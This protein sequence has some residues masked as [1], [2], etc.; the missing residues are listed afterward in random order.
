MVYLI[1]IRNATL[2]KVFT[3]VLDFVYAHVN[4]QSEL[5][6]RLGTMTKR[7]VRHCATFELCLFTCKI[8]SYQSP[9]GQRTSLD[10]ILDDQVVS[11]N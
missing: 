4:D 1:H 6:I 10:S 8:E 5:M 11:N 7:S 2:V 9:G 3:Y